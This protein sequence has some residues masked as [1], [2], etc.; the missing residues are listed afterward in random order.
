MDMLRIRHLPASGGVKVPLPHPQRRSGA[1][2]VAWLYGE[3]SV[4]SLL[5]HGGI[6]ASMLLLIALLDSVI[7][8]ANRDKVA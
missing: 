3:A 8:Q 7:W 1:L 5:L 2:T 4:Q 6:A